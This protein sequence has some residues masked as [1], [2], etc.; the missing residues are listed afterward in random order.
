MDPSSMQ[1]VLLTAGVLTATGVSLFF[2]LKGD[3]VLCVRCGGNGGTKCV[4]CTDGKMK[5]DEGLVDC[6][7]CR[8]AGLI[9]CKNC[10]GSGYST[11]L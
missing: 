7:V 3:P 10:K 4:F 8:G 1:T 2:G 11:R 5:T 6:K 9:M